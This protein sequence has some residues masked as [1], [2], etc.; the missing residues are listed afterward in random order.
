MFNSYPYDKQPTYHIFRFHTSF[1]V[2]FAGFT[3]FLQWRLRLV[4][5][6]GDSVTVYKGTY[7]RTPQQETSCFEFHRSQAQLNILLVVKLTAQT[8]SLL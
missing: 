8:I 1:V 7:V 6:G 2:S 3:F 4:K 5:R